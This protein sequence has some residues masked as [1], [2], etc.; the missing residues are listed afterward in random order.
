MKYLFLIFSII[1]LGCSQ[2]AEKS[3]SVEIVLNDTIADTVSVKSFSDTVNKIETNPLSV[4][5]EFATKYNPKENR[6]LPTIN[7]NIYNSFRQL[8][9]N[10]SIEYE[11][12]LTLVFIKLYRSHVECCHQ[13]YELRR[14]PPSPKI[15]EEKDT[16]LFLFNEMTSQFKAEKP[17]EFISS[18]IAYDWAKSK[19][20]LSNDRLIKDNLNR[21]DSVNKEIE[22]ELNR[23]LNSQNDSITFKLIEKKLQDSHDFKIFKLVLKDNKEYWFQFE[24]MGYF[25]TEEGIYSVNGDTLI[26]ES[27]KANTHRYFLFVNSKENASFYTSQ[28]NQKYPSPFL[29]SYR[30]N[31]DVNV[32]NPKP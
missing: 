28:K 13:S 27:L 31:L 19:R 6:M 22:N 7:K 23:M 25:A 1:L 14:Q 29:K 18:S 20:I 5:K 3:E 26:L 8:K 17:I 15:E 2:S 30:L 4:V 16:L 21:I 10:D 24:N 11:K 12:Y 32:N 9:K